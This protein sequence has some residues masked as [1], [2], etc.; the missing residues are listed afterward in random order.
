MSL[1]RSEAVQGGGHRAARECNIV[2]PAWTTNG[3][4][5]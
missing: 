1:H 2:M 5:V 4:N 3:E